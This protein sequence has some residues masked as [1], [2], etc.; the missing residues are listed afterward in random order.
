MEISLR[1]LNRATLAR[2]MLL[3]REK[4]SALKAIERL[5]AMQAQLPRP[6]FVG[7]WTR[8][9]G[10]DRAALHKLLHKR[11][12]VRGTLLRGTLHLLS[13][14]DYLQFRPLFQ[15]MLEGAIAQVLRERA[16][17][18]NVG[19]L[20]RQA[21]SLLEAGPRTFEQ[22]RA[23]LVRLNPGKDER[24][25][26]YAVRCA[27]ELL[28]V[29]IE[30]PWS[31]PTDAAFT[32]A[33]GWLGKAA[34]AKGLGPL[35]LRYLAAFGP[36]SV[37]DMQAWSGMKDLADAFEAL[38]PKLKVFRDA[39]GKELFDL[40][41]APRPDGD[42]PAPVRFLPD[43]DNLVLGHHHRAR[44]IADAHRPHV[45]TKN[46]QVLP[47]FLVDGFVAGTWKIDRA[48][49]SATLTLKPFD[50]L[51]K[52]AKDEL[53]HEGAGLLKFVEP[54]AGKQLVLFDYNDER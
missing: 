36:A 30:A 46:L 43:F 28:Q 38:R 1:Q 33:E 34:E 23:E 6:P 42:V 9:A 19:Q 12:A 41:K 11:S 54:D 29:P 31:F 53:T 45:T 37:A 21:R 26:G 39:R 7:L 49:A 10:F 27:L 16:K 48:R 8:V 44:V 50:P 18:L 51:P 3:A 4:T 17:D 13:A 20:G 40:P 35:V 32:L 47:T 14:K 52:K 24:A 22:I 25:M 2:Q 5:V 15:P